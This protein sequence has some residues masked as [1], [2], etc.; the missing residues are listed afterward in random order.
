M[1]K[2]ENKAVKKGPKRSSG[3]KTDVLWFFLSR[4]AAAGEEKESQVE[5]LWPSNDI[6]PAVDVVALSEVKT[7]LEEVDGGTAHCRASNSAKYGP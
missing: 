3:P 4:T 2:W 1:N 6:L 7:T 5:R